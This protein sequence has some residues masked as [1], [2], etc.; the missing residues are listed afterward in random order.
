M[1][2]MFFIPIAA[3][4]LSFTACNSGENKTETMDT[5]ETDQMRI[6]AESAV[7]DNQMSPTTDSQ[8]MNNTTDSA[9]MNMSDT[10][11]MNK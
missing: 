1:T 11:R 3:A 2:K 7:Q 5:M 8:M 6:E 4:V 10:Q 9:M